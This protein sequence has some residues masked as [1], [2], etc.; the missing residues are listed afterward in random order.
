MFKQI[1]Y[2]DDE[3]WFIEP[4]VDALRCDGY[5]VDLASNATE[6]IEKLV[7]DFYNPDLVILDVIMPSG[8]SLQ[9]TNGGRRTGIKVFEIIRKNLN[10]RVPVLFLTVVDNLSI[11]REIAFLET[12]NGFGNFAV[13]VKPALPNEVLEKASSMI[14]LSRR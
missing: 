12:P 5:Q 2:V 8:N 11:E 13:L 4:I 10:L 14:A 3:P 1:L 6:A 9:E 7:R